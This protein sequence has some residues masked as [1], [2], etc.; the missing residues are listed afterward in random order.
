MAARAVRWTSSP[1][2]RRCRVGRAIAARR[3]ASSLLCGQLGEAEA[4]DFTATATLSVDFEDGAQPGTVSGEIDGFM[5]GG[6]EKD[7][8]VELGSAAISTDGVIAV[9]GSDT[10]LTRWTIGDSTAETTGTWS[11]QFHD[12]D[13]DRTP[14]VA[15][16]VF[17]AV[18]G[19]IGH[20]TGA[21]GTTR[22]P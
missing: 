1:I 15:T 14:V 19:I 18:H 7:W 10:A 2:W 11:G 22:Q 5:V 17:E 20:M 13:Q 21:F 8:E 3:L 4:G 12:A 6:R 16:G 9:G